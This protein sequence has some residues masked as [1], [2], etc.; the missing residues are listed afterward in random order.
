[1]NARDANVSTDSTVLR[2]GGHP[3]LVIPDDTPAYAR[4]ALAGM[5]RAISLRAARPGE[6]G[7]GADGRL[8]VAGQAYLRADGAT[9]F[10]LFHYLR[11]LAGQVAARTA[12]L[13]MP[14]QTWSVPD[15]SPTPAVAAHASRDG[16][17]PVQGETFPSTPRSTAVRITGSPAAMR[18]RQRAARR[19]GHDP[20]VESRM[21]TWNGAAAQGPRVAGRCG[22]SSR[23]PFPTAIR[24]P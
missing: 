2:R 1:V 10:F 24:E 7:A 9:A 4:V 16:E 3:P 23:A 8:A 6:D 17:H 20:A 15:W 14:A 21:P 22:H 5:D 12:G 11:L 13:P 19:P 18:A